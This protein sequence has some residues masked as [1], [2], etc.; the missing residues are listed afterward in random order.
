MTDPLGNLTIQSELS[1]D[2]AAGENCL[3]ALIY[4]EDDET[5]HVQFITDTSAALSPSEFNQVVKELTDFVGDMY[6]DFQT[7]EKPKPN[8]EDG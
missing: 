4:Q 7:D 1:F 5:C 8:V 2:N 3:R 6:A